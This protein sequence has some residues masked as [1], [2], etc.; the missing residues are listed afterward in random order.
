ME[1]K[2]PASRG[3]MDLSMLGQSAP[4]TKILKKLNA[5]QKKVTYM[6]K[7]GK[8]SAQGYSYLTEAQITDMFKPLLESAGVFFAYSSQITGSQLSPTGK[9]IVTD[10]S[11]VYQFL[12]IDSGEAMVGIAA[13]QGSDGNDKGVF[14]GITG[15]VKYIFMKTFLIPTGNDP[16]DDSPKGKKSGIATQKD[17]AE[18]EPFPDED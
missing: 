11:V 16:E 3:A 7:D 18:G 2:I 4:Q 8:N 17:V 9:Q 5:I 14:K 13:G 6:S 1:E 15:A 12:D 10:V